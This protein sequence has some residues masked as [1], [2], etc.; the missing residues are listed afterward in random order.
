MKNAGIYLLVIPKYWGKQIFTHGIFPKVGQKQKTEKKKKERLNDSNNSGR[1]FSLE[2]L[3]FITKWTMSAITVTYGYFGS[4][5]RGFH[6]GW[7][8]EFEL[9]KKH[10]TFVFPTLP[11]YNCK[12]CKTWIIFMSNWPRRL[13]VGHP[14]GHLQC[15]AG[16]CYY[17]CLVSLL[18]SFFFSVF[19]FWPTSGNLAWKLVSPNILA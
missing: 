1:L 16:H 3:Y 19:C 5:L 4:Q 6:F 15:V 13:C 17:H 12:C 10:I 7:Q 11:V 9:E 18:S 8:P 14:R 2:C